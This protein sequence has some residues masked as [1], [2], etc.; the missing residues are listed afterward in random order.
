M[1]T[2]LKTV[3]ANYQAF[4]RKDIPAILETLSPQVCWQQWGD[5]SAQ[6]AGLPFMLERNGPDG[7]MAFFKAIGE[8]LEVHSLRVLNLAAS[9]RLVVAEIELDWTVRA[10]GIRILDQ[11]L[12]LWGFD[13]S[14]RVDRYRNYLDTAKHIQAHGLALPG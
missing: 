3:Q 10:T 13:E 5:N 1:N 6:R 4:G 2:P 12:H 7:V 11:V 8:G 9:E 14:G